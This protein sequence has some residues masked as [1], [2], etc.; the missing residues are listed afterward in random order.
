M[1]SEITGGK[2]KYLLL[3]LA[4]ISFELFG[5]SEP[6]TQLINENGSKMYAPKIRV[7]HHQTTKISSIEA[8]LETENDN[9]LKNPS[10]ES[11]LIETMGTLGWSSNA[12]KSFSTDAVDGKQAIVI[13]GNIGLS[14][15]PKIMSTMIAINGATLANQIII[16]KAWYKGAGLNNSSICILPTDGSGPVDADKV[17]T[18][19][20]DSNG[21]WITKIASLRVKST[22]IGYQI[23]LGSYTVSSNSETFDK[24]YASI[25]DPKDQAT[26]LGFKNDSKYELCTFSTFSWSGFGTVNPSLYCMRD[27][28]TLRMKG[29]VVFG[30][31]TAVEGRIPLPSNYGVIN[32]HPFPSSNSSNQ[33]VGT[34]Y[35]ALTAPNKGGVVLVS[36]ASLNYLGLSTSETISSASI[37]P[38]VFGIAS[39][40]SSAGQT[41]SFDISVPIAEWS[42]NTNGALVTCKEGPV[43]CANEYSASITT[44]SGLVENEDVD[45]ITSCTAA[46]PTVCTLREPTVNPLTCTFGGNITVG[47]VIRLVSRTTTTLT[48]GSYNSSTGA[49]SN[50]PFDIKCTKQGSDY[51]AGYEKV[52]GFTEDADIRSTEWLTGGFDYI[53]AK[54]IYRRCH[55]VASDITTHNATVVTWPANLNPIGLN[56]FYAD[57]WSISSYGSNTNGSNINYTKSSGVV[58]F[59]KNGTLAKIGSGTTFCMDYVK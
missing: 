24:A 23:I 45:W 59:E 33:L 14:R 34:F 56:N 29:S 11:P 58:S 44:G 21:L 26:I 28:N 49:F 8:R 53:S 42:E 7:P 18:E 16:G 5:Q 41:A 30:T 55:K 54:P 35:R 43:K 52:L 32:T 57:S 37:N 46:N 6:V 3:L 27:G 20:G 9:A 15:M 39:T 25:Y 47:A 31:T 17:C 4:F 36:P 22:Y 1:V 13:T 38:M 19:F 50:T 51:N 10:F 12:N 40:I 2:M 48:L